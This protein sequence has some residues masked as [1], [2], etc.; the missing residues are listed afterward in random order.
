[1]VQN[2]SMIGISQP[3]SNKEILCVYFPVMAPLVDVIACR[4]LDVDE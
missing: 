1:M 2:I 4:V 3:L